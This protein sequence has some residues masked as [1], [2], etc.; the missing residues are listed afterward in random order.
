[1]HTIYAFN[2]WIRILSYGN[3]L[4]L[5]GSFERWF[6]IGYAHFHMLLCWLSLAD[7]FILVIF[8]GLGMVYEFDLLVRGLHP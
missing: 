7:G 6:S 4:V 5:E 3:E 2:S 1:M 8:L